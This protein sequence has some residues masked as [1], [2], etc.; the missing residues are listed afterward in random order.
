MRVNVLGTEY[1]ILYDT[2]EEEM[3]ENAD[4]CMDQSTKTIKLAKFETN[5]NSIQNMKDYTKKY[6][7]M[8]LSTPF[9]MNQDCG[10][11]VVMF[12]RGDNAKK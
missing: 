11:T 6:C 9:C 7:D 5:R 10:I 2:P 3:P 1:I 8:K 12:K 4:G